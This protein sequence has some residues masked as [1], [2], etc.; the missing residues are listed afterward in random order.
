MNKIKNLFTVITVVTLTLSSCSSL[1]TLSNGKQIDKNL[2]GIWEGSETDKQVQGLKKDWQMTRSDDGTFILNFKTTYEGETEELIEKG[3]WWVKGKLFFEYHENS[4][5]TDTYKYVL[6]NKDQAKFEMINTEVEFED[7]NYTF[8]D[9]RVSDTKSKDSA[10]D[11]LSIENAI[12]VKSIAEEYEYA[13]KNCHDCELL[14][15]SL[16]E[17]KGKPYDE[18][19]FKNADGQEVSY[20]FDI[21]SFYGKW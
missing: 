13:R 18:L 2:V 15:Q 8:I 4:D 3:N 10:K 17:H 14:G 16:L 12:K 19:R 20:Y 6:L 1:K 7:K 9:T 5:E 11:G 21:S